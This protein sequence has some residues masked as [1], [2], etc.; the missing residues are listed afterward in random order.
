MHGR[1]GI[2][3]VLATATP[4]HAFLIRRQSVTDL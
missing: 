1:I 2:E 4:S 3:A